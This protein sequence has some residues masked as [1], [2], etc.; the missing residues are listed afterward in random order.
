MLSRLRSKNNS[1]ILQQGF[2]Q[3]FAA[4]VVRCAVPAEVGAFAAHTHT[5]D[6]FQLEFLSG[7]FV[8]LFRPDSQ[9]CV[10][11]AVASGTELQGVGVAQPKTGNPLDQCLKKGHFDFVFVGY[12][13]KGI[14]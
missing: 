6:K 2:Q 8:E 3:F 5:G 11:S 1:G 7:S 10:L 14:V 9:L 13:D 4:V 12:G